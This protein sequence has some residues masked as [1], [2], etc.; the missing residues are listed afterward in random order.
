MKQKVE[1]MYDEYPHLAIPGDI[2]QTVVNFLFLPTFSPSMYRHLATKKRYTMSPHTFSRLPL[3]PSSEITQH[4][5]P[6]IDPSL[7]SGNNT[8]TA[9][10]RSR[11]F[12]KDGVWARVTP[13]PIAFPYRLPRAQEGEVQLGVEEWLGDWDKFEGEDADGLSAKA[14]EKRN[15][16]EPEI[17]GF[18]EECARDCLPTLDFGNVLE[19]TGQRGD[20]DEQLD[21][22]AQELVDCISGKRVITGTVEGKEYGP[23]STRYAGESVAGSVGSADVVQ[24][25]NSGY[26]PVNWATDALLASVSSLFRSQYAAYPLSVETKTPDGRR[27]EIQLKGAGRTPF[28][29]SADGLAVLRSGVR[30]FLGA[31]GEYSDNHQY[32]CSQRFQQWPLYE[33][34]LL[35]PSH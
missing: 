18:S 2:S 25:I 21:V 3:P 23:W 27:Q 9:Q 4:N 32:Q 13:L 24:A 12:P 22:N 8:H 14:S 15:R 34:R 29:R 11:T 28:S 10:R 1:A 19:Y 16:L 17:L 26:G 31:E 30:E 6:R 33:F 35:V 7:P 5:L 20:G